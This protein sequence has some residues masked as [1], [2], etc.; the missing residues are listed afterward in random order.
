MVDARMNAG[1]HS[2]QK[3]ID[4]L[5]RKMADEIV[6]KQNITDLE[7]AK[8]FASNWIQTAAQHADNEEYYRKDLARL[9]HILDAVRA[10][11]T[12]LA[13]PYPPGCSCGKIKFK[14]I[15]DA[16]DELDGMIRIEPARWNR[17]RI[18]WQNTRY[19]WWRFKSAITWRWRRIFPQ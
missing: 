13:R 18:L 14:Q 16:L 17:I 4:A 10:L 9:R 2:N 19:F 5:R 8:R 1:S 11:L 6:S 12:A 3:K 15:C 7:H